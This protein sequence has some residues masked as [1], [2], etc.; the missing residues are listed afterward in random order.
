MKILGTSPDAIDIAEDRRRFEK[1]ARELG[2]EQP[3]NGTATSVDEALDGRGANRLS[4][5]GA[6]VVRARRARDADRVRRA[7]ARSDYFET[8][9]RVSEE[10]PGARRPLPR[11]RVRVRRR[12][13]LATA[14]AS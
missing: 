8:A 13:D 12:R 2:L 14:R 3:P 11:G 9:V 6:A 5:A 1:I 10:R 4:G 7:V